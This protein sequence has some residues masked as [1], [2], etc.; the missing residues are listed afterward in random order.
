MEYGMSSRQSMDYSKSSS[1]SMEYSTS[2]SESVRKGRKPP[3]VSTGTGDYGM[4]SD[5]SMNKLKPIDGAMSSSEEYSKSSIESSERSISESAQGTI[6]GTGRRQKIPVVPTLPVE[7]G[8]SSSTS[9]ESTMSSSEEYSKSSSE[10]VKN[11]MSS[12]ET[13]QG[14][15]GGIG[16]RQKTP[17]VS[18]RPGD[19]G[20]TVRARANHIDG[21]LKYIDGVHYELKRRVQ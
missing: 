4:S 7:Y 5:T 19:Y 21:E 15:I 10:S 3:I 2:S 1:E 16:R 9:M 13:V 11:T 12:S 14:T 20:I 18:T 8:M 17:V 6:G